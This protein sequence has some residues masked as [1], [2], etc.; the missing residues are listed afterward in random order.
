VLLA[1]ISKHVSR[2]AH[3]QYASALQAY[4]RG[5]LDKAVT[6]AAE[7][8]L[9]Q[10]DN[11]RLAIDLVKLL[12]LQKRYIQADDLINS[13]PDE[14]RQHPEISNLSAHVSFIRTPRMPRPSRLSIS[15]LP[16]SR[17]SRG[18]LSTVRGPN[19]TGQF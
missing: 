3:S 10:P 8:A 2:E 18:S 19:N 4:Q 9:T 14:A 17:G 5:D 11:S 7:A 12:M 13:L 15:P 1:F 16:K 6:Q